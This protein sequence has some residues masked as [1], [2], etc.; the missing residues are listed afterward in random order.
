[1]V[2]ASRVSTRSTQPIGRR[3]DCLPPQTAV[4]RTRMTLSYGRPRLR[5]TWH[6]AG[7]SRNAR[8]VVAGP[9]V[10]LQA[11][12]LSAAAGQ[13]VRTGAGTPRASPLG[14]LELAATDLGTAAL[15]LLDAGD[16]NMTGRFAFARHG[17]SLSIAIG[18][19]EFF[20]SGF[21]KHAPR[22]RKLGGKPPR[23]PVCCV[24]AAMCALAVFWISS[25]ACRSRA[26][27]RT[28]SAGCMFARFTW[29]PLPQGKSTP[30]TNP[31]V[32]TEAPIVPL[33]FSPE[34]SF[35]DVIGQSES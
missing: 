14:R 9:H 6:R 27:H 17:T 24:A 12:P 32:G 1:M 21:F 30:S 4:E 20:A 25:S 16:A 15:A 29:R 5:P 7:R 34:F 23:Q 3:G 19:V 13:D 2:V 8:D 28:T 11:F 31:R 26:S 33:F 22:R 35:V 18:E 10:G